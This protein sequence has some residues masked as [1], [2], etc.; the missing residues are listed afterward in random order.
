[1]NSAIEIYNLDP[2]D[3]VNMDETNFY[4]DSPSDT[5]LAKK[6]AKTIGIS[7]TGSSSRCT[8]ML[9][10]TL[11]GQKLPPMIIFKGTA[12]GIIAKNELP[13]E[14]CAND[15]P[16]GIVYATQES[17]WNDHRTML[18]W[19]QQIWEP[20]CQKNNRKKC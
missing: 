16:G 11:S 12:A 5:T 7:D 19:V 3:I 9:A 6:G 8:V 15:Y 18:V 20:W 10:V 1:M 13:Q 14:G 17:A 2:E 4:F